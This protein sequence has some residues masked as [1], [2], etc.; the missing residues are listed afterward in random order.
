MTLDLKTIL[1]DLRAQLPHLMALYLFGSAAS[2]DAAAHSDVD[3][4]VLVEGKVN[5][6]ALWY[7]AQRLASRIGRDV[8]LVDLRAA[9]T[10]LQYQI[11]TTGRCLW[12]RDARA[13]IYES[14]ILSEKTAL[15]AL[16]R[17]LLH[18]IEQTGSVYGR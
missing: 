8:D 12:A 3:L 13:A 14:F 5:T 17:D 1:H 4:A 9:S 6:V 18:D 2:G 10:V 11:I 16:R 15:D 7:L